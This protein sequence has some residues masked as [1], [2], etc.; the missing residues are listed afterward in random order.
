MND[1][2]TAPLV[3][4]GAEAAALVENARAELTAAVKRARSKAAEVYKP[5]HGVLSRA[6][7]LAAR[8]GEQFDDLRDTGV[9]AAGSARR[10]RRL[11]RPRHLS[12]AGRRR[13]LCADEHRRA[14]PEHRA[15][16]RPRAAAR[17]RTRASSIRIFDVFPDRIYFTAKL[18]FLRVVEALAARRVF[19]RA[20][21][22]LHRFRDGS[23]KQRQG[24]KG[25][26]QVSYAAGTLEDP[27]R[28]DA[29]SASTRTSTSI[30]AP[31]RTCSARCW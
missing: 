17:W 30:A 1:L 12:R 15:R 29:A 20:P 14:A 4:D 10:L 7:K 9:S 8:I 25:N 3:G 19:E 27:A 23:Y 2:V 5:F 6:E 16:A 21:A 28:P 24:R 26:V 22:S 11:H 18:E 13:A 31:S